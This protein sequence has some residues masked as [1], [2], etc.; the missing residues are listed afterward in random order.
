MGTVIPGSASH[1][2]EAYLA[3]NA[4]HDAFSMGY[5]DLNKQL[6]EVLN[7]AVLGMASIDTSGIYLHHVIQAIMQQATHSRDLLLSST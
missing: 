7:F 6:L 5:K 1:T 4:D 3:E 2:Q